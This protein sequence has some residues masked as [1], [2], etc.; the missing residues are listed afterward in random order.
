MGFLDWIIGEKPAPKE[1]ISQKIEGSKFT[2]IGNTEPICPYCNF[3]LNKMPQKKKKCPNCNNFIRSRTRPLDNKK[4][5]IKEDQMKELAIQW[6]IKN[7][8]SGYSILG[9]KPE[10]RGHYTPVS[11]NVITKILNKP[12]SEVTIEDRQKLCTSDLEMR[13]SAEVKRKLLQYEPCV[14]ISEDM[15]THHVSQEAIRACLESGK[16]KGLYPTLTWVI[17]PECCPIESHKLLDGQTIDVDEKFVVP[18]GEWKGYEAQVPGEFG[19]PALDYNC[20]CWV[21]GD[22]RVRNKTDRKRVT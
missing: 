7:E 15:N 5:L 22:M 6:A 12:W 17:P 9:R 10:D 8:Q 1:D 13:V 16:E 4:V 19:E 2:A 18:S 21:V 3:K 14:D 20:R 11:S